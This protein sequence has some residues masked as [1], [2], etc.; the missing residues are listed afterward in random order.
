[1]KKTPP[2]TSKEC[3]RLSDYFQT[4]LESAKAKNNRVIADLCVEFLGRIKQIRSE[5]KDTQMELIA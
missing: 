1:M 5:T 2:N 3:D 4:R